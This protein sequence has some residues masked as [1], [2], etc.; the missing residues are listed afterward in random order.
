MISRRDLYAMGEP[1]GDSCTRI[2][3]GRLICGGGG[4][5]GGKSTTT[6]EIPKELKPLATA[7]ANKAMGLSNTPYQAYGGQQVAD[8]N[9]YQNAAT[10][11]LGEMFNSGDSAMN[12]ARNTVTNSLN[13]GQAATQNPYGYIGNGGNNQYAGSN[14]YLQQN[15]D[16]ALGD[17]T[18]NYNNA[19]APGLTTQMVNSGSFG[20]TGAQAA[21]QNAMNDLTKNLANTASGMRMQD[22]GNQ[23]QL[24]ESQI[25][26]NLQTNQFNA[27]LGQD[28]ASRNDSLRGQMLGLAPG[29][30]NQQL[31]VA[32]NFMNAANMYQDNQQQ[33]LDAQYQNYLDQQNDPYKKLAAMAGVFGSG[34][35][36]TTTTKSS[37]GGK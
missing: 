34:L 10:A 29:Y 11:R 2:E 17:I 36:T 32:N 5:G 23:Q 7:Y 3:A 28:Y 20:N 16:A 33:K 14:P 6:T 8:I 25:N 18:R 21:T 4:G 19:V 22:Y 27:G 15:I 24:A 13:S 1:F 35:G 9:P 26:R 30:E 31:G 37:G 12:A